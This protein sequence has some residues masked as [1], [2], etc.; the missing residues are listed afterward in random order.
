MSDIT[1]LPIAMTVPGRECVYSISQ[2]RR[3]I[4]TNYEEFFGQHIDQAQRVP[5]VLNGHK[6]EQKAYGLHDG[7]YIVEE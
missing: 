6:Q 3:P 7:L 4:V 2:L 1:L 5:V